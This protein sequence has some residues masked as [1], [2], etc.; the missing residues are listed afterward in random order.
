MFSLF[1]GKPDHPLFDLDEA[2]RLIA[3]LPE[4]D[5]SKALEDITFWLDSIKS[6]KGFQPEQ[7]ATI[8]LLL[9][10][11]A[12][13][14]Y[15]GFLHQYLSAPHLQDF[16]GVHQWQGIHAYAR[17]LSEAYAASV[18]EYR[19]T[20]KHTFER[21]Q[22]MPLLCVRWG[23]AIGE[24]MKLELMRYLDIELALWQ[25]IAACQRFIE[26]E[27]IAENM[28]LAYAGNVIHA[29]P[30][31]ELLRVLMM[32]VAAPDE[33]APD[34]IEVSYRIAGRLCSFF[35]LK[36]AADTDCPYQLDIAA[37]TAPQNVQGETAA[38]LRYFGA[39]RAL[40][41][42]DKIEKQNEDDPVWQ[43][44]RFGSE[45]TPG[46]KLTVLKHLLT[47]W[48]AQPPLHH[49][50]HRAINTTVEVI[51]GFRLISQMV[52]RIEL[53]AADAEKQQASRIGLAAEEEIDFSAEV[54]TVSDI[55]LDEIGIKLAKSAGAWVKVGDLC[56]IKTQNNPL[57]W[58]G[59]IRRI[60]TDADN[61][62]HLVVGIIAKKPLSIWL[63][64]LGKG[65]EKASNWETSSGSFQYTYL[66]AIL[67]PDAQNSLRNA[68]LLMETGAF[69]PGNFYQALMGDNSRDIKLVRLMAEGEDY[70]QVGIEWAGQA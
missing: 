56:G 64:A 4:D 44:R 23:R 39:V 50:D 53:V 68:T 47:W 1:E 52:T 46:G 66:P 37:G 16:K 34:Q 19:A 5:L 13:T 63:R 36:P 40:A 58:V 61:N 62:V 22:Q 9:D 2:R 67:M 49:Q 30:Q 55:S 11:T 27:Q 15:T 28:V 20:D 25:Q 35:D 32:Y 10:E 33:L 29:S 17:A 41:A 59:A 6:T 60:H 45:F 65:A 14:I 12:L 7:R 38:D 54:W 43:E 51:H 48:A 57:W 70:E 21:R 26:A 31:R 69:V 18:E 42:V 24:Q 8:I 3:E